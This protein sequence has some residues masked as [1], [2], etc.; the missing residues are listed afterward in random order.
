MDVD[1]NGY[2]GEKEIKYN[3]FVWVSSLHMYPAT[4][5]GGNLNYGYGQESCV[6]DVKL[7]GTWLWN[8]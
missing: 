3:V 2:N 4:L 6:Y 1:N 7:C 5:T 8:V